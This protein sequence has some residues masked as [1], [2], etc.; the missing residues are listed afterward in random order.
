MFDNEDIGITPDSSSVRFQFKVSTAENSELSKGFP[1]FGCPLK[2]LVL[3]TQS[4][5][6]S[7]ETTRLI[8]DGEVGEEGGRLYTY[9]YTVPTRM[10]CIKMVSDESHFNVS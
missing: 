6:K 5:P 1:F 3:K 8:R 2:S 4:Y 7:T 9:R 10:T